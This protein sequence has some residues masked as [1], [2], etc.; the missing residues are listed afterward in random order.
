MSD[1]S[2][3]FD[4]KLKQLTREFEVLLPKKLFQIEETWRKYTNHKKP[5]K[6]RLAE[7]KR[8][9][10]TLAGSSASFGFR[11]LGNKARTLESRIAALSQASD[12]QRP[13]I[14]KEIGVRIRELHANLH[15]SGPAASTADVPVQKQ[16]P[17]PASTSQEATQKVLWVSQKESH[18]TFYCE[19]LSLFGFDVT[20]VTPQQLQEQLSTQQVLAGAIVDASS[21]DPDSRQSQALLAVIET[22]P[23]HTPIILVTPENEAFAFVL[24]AIQKGV[25]V[26]LPAPISLP[27]L[28]A[29]LDQFIRP[30]S[31]YRYRLFVL[32]DD[33]S[34]LGQ[35]ENIL[36][37]A[38][39]EVRGCS[40]PETAIPLLKAF[41]P[42]LILLDFHLPGCTGFDFALMLRQ[43][44]QFKH[45]PVV[46]LSGEQEVNHRLEALETGGE[47][48]LLKPIRY[49]YLY[50]SL[51]PRMK[52]GRELRESLKKDALTGLPNHT[53]MQRVLETTLLDLPENKPLVFALL[54]IDHFQRIN[55]VH[56]HSIGDHVIQTLAKL[57]YHRLNHIG[58]IGRYG[59]EEFAVILPHMDEGEAQKVLDE[60]RQDFN[61]LQMLD[62][63]QETFSTSFSCG[64][65][66]Y[67]EFGTSSELTEGADKALFQAKSMG[68]DRV[69]FI[70][71]VTRPG[72]AIPRWH[73][74]QE[75]PSFSDFVDDAAH[76]V[77]EEDML[78]DG[79]PITAVREDTVALD[80]IPFTTSDDA[81]LLFVDD[82]DDVADD[83]DAVSEED[84]ELADELQA[85]TTPTDVDQIEALDPFK[86]LDAAV[87]AGD[88]PV[89]SDDDPNIAAADQNT[90][91][92]LET[93]SIPPLVIVVDDESHILELVAAFVRDRGYRV[94]T[95]A[96]GDEAFARCF[97][98]HP[99][100][101]ITDLLLFPGIHGFELC[102][103]IK[104]HPNLTEVKVIVMTAVYK[105]YRYRLEARE[106]GADAFIEKPIDFDVLRDALK[107]L[108]PLDASVVSG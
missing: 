106:A 74:M 66:G 100:L 95:A 40:D 27:N 11:D 62:N 35:I 6:E 98:D 21:L 94:I 70:G 105:N 92:L 85:D 37:K 81:E 82:E 51:L 18:S 19:Q 101:V 42:D 46:Y 4:E 17:Q 2:S 80:A 97:K 83:F 7:V 63:N 77:D 24:D 90:D 49:R 26:C 47:D 30:P 64:L 25:K 96:T 57:L 86:A 107:E 45:V 53:E 102:E 72:G 9:I 65:A 23:D 33:S 29:K 73:G 61:Q 38:G 28:V 8:L 93:Q 103:R 89:F 69:L 36:G 87:A 76:F 68:R 78:H 67:P 41:Q 22:I 84:F 3:S 104:K 13:G 59:G 15:R 39:M 32:D 48:F 54:D 75:T 34:L 14:L 12:D 1:T 52:R 71:H 43:Y 5:D 56:G 99:G 20:F 10:H 79:P 91:A 50:Y 31:P 60:V 44:D 88:F 55:E 108:L 58:W 16:E